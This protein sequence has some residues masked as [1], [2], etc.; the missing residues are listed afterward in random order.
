[1]KRSD[2]E[3]Q[4][5][6]LKTKISIADLT[7]KFYNICCNNCHRVTS[8]HKDHIFECN[9]YG[10]KQAIGMPRLRVE[11]KAT[12]KTGSIIASLYGENAQKVLHCC[13]E[14]LATHF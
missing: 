9:F 5:F 7:Q 3:Q 12:Y 13:A 6:W 10:E 1:L 14:T 11:V 4:M 2:F 8:A